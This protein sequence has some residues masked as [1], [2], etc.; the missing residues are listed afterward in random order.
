[1][2]LVPLP[3]RTQLGLGEV[4]FDWR[5]GVFA[6]AVTALTA[7]VASLAPARRLVNSNAID[8]L[9]QQS[10]GS[11]GPRAL[12]QGLVVGEVALAATLLLIAGLMTDN[13]SRLV[14]ADLGV[15]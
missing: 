14:S 4:A 6:S 2:D 3:L 15:Q 10:R 13:L 12:M 11:T 1:M 7:V 5:V 8:A 9:R